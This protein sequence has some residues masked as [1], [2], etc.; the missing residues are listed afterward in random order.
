MFTA[1]VFVGYDYLVQRRQKNTLAKATQMGGIV[2]SLF[3]ANVRDR[4]IEENEAQKQGKAK[5]FAMGPH[6]KEQLRSFLGSESDKKQVKPAFHL[7]PI[8]DLFPSCTVMFADIANFTAWSS[9]RE[10]SQV[11]MLLETIYHEF[12]TLAKRRKVFKV[13][14]IGDC[15]V[16][17][18]GLPEPNSQHP[19]IM[20][21]FA[22]EC[23]QRMSDV[24]KHLEVQLGP[25]TGELEIRIGL[26]S[27]PVTAGVLRGE[28]SRFQLFGDTVNTASRI[29]ASGE[30]SKIHISNETASLLIQMNKEHWVRERGEVVEAKGKGILKTYWLEFASESME[31]SSDKDESSVSGHLEVSRTVDKKLDRLIDWNTDVLARLIKQIIARRNVAIKLGRL[32]Q[33]QTVPTLPTHVKEKTVLEEVVEIIPLPS[34][35]AELLA[36]G[37]DYEKVNLDI[38]V[39]IQLRSFIASVAAMYNDNPFHNF[40]HASHVTM[41]VTKLLSR[42]LSPDSW[43][44]EDERNKTP[45]NL[46]NITYG[47]TSDPMTQFACVFSA[48]IHD[49]DHTGVPNTTLVK[50]NSALAQVYKGKSVAEQNS[51]DLSWS[52]FMDDAY[53]KLRSAICA[54]DQE[55]IR[56]RQLV[57]SSVMATD[58]MDKDLKKLRNERWDKAFSPKVESAVV[59]SPANVLNRKATIVI[60]HLIQAS[61][62]AHTMQHWHVFRSWNEK[63]FRELYVAYKAGRADKD[64]S[65][66]WYQGEIGFFD[67][68]ILPLAKK[69]K[70]CGVFGVSSDEY[71]NYAE[72]NRREWEAKGR[73]VVES[74]VQKIEQEDAVV[75]EAQ[76]GGKRSEGGLATM[77]EEASTDEPNTE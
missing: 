6:Q 24:T 46:H 74:M 22:K 7:K 71:L 38:D 76:S 37:Q 75:A 17:V 67:F 10:P 25:D 69:L 49:A 31:N 18:C 54:N 41:S 43:L 53:A 48:L 39:K 5:S 12:D 4:L 33:S 9:V 26:H 28:K 16:A 63:L 40:E 20:A 32:Q 44:G 19:I 36:E 72:K 56:F 52:L 62:V 35:D 30:R 45:Q 64:P 65:E 2:A 77:R 57:V 11:F 58:I 34:F 68:Y 51:V 21:R 15:Y 59:E 23:I 13:E 3:P 29:E 73:E 55:L 70:D 27:G 60:E 42:I 14:T 50:E 61:D 47:I 8:A 1:A 66:F